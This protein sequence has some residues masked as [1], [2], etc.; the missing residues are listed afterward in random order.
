VRPLNGYVIALVV[1]AIYASILLVGRRLKW[2][3]RL[4]IKLYGPVMMLRTSRGQALISRLGSRTRAWNAYGLVAV[5]ISA[6]MTAVITGFL[7]WEVYTTYK[8]QNLMDISSELLFGQTHIDSLVTAVYVVVGI[9]VAVLTHELSHGVLSVVNRIK[10]RSIGLMLLVV[11]IGAFVEPDDDQLKKASRSKRLRVFAAG[12]AANAI[13][14]AVFMLI[15]LGAL[16]PSVRPVSE[17]PVVVSVAPNSPA[18]ISG[19]EVWSGLT[20]LNG[21]PTSKNSFESMSFNMP[22]ELVSVNLTYR[23]HRQVL[24]LPGGVVVSSVSDGPAF[25]AGIEQGMIIARLNGSVIHSVAELRS[26]VENST[27]NSPVNITVLRFGHD[28]TGGINWFVE[29]NSIHSVNLTSK[30]LYYRLHFPSLNREEY[31]NIS[32]LGVGSS[33]LGIEVA[34][35]REVLSPVTHPL[36]R[37]G[38]P[39]ARVLDFLRYLGLPFFGYSPMVSPEADLYEPSG[40]MS[41]IPPELFWVVSNVCYWIFWANLML[42]L[43]NALPAVPMDGGMVISDLLKG[44]TKRF[45]DRLSGLDLII[46]KKPISE[47]QV[48]RFM[49]ALTVTMAIVIAYLVLWQAFG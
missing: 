31:R 6:S 3:A 38:G 4:G 24:A 11:P 34:D 45:G 49:V 36:G 42:A 37:E 15:L 33:P 7:A 12:P 26:V 23:H 10:L 41:A 47:R 21:K 28:T 48:D 39:D 40:I 43:T 8:S 13:V 20:E 2:W 32:F 25:N 14:A 27:R 22:G 9:S 18:D 1:S 19:I 46:G 16:M 17:G 5:I 44:L 30:W 29:D 35:A